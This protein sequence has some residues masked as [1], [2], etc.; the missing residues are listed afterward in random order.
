MS[1]KDMIERGKRK[2]RSKIITEKILN[3]E[4]PS[5][6]FFSR[7][8]SQKLRNNENT[9]SQDHQSLEGIILNH[10]KSSFSG[11]REERNDDIESFCSRYNIYLP[12][13]NQAEIPEISVEDVKEAANN[14]RNKSRGGPDNLSAKYTKLFVKIMPQFIHSCILREVNLHPTLKP[15]TTLR[16]RQ[17]N[18][19]LIKKKNTSANIAKCYR[20][21]S[22]LNTFFKFF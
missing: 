2:S 18:I 4:T 20:P 10:F 5:P 17:R 11:S 3:N 15:T 8:K 7:L 21:I 14:M 6:L 19:S 22:L 12:Q 1:L 16:L 13:I 9:N